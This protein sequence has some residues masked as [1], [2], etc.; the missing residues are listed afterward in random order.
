MRARGIVL[1]LAIA[2]LPLAAHA[3]SMPL[4]EQLA[5]GK[6]LAQAS[7]SACHVIPGGASGGSDSAPT[8]EKIAATR[9]DDFL[10]T[11]L[12]KPHGN[13]PPVDLTN[14]QIGA[15]IAYIESLKK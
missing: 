9:G 7:C 4:Q 13:M 3:E 15:L 2:A 1:T 5:A 11:F 8:F 12:L 14:V 10:R 6:A